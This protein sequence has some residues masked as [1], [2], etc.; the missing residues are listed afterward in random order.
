MLPLLDVEL[1]VN[2]N[3]CEAQI[4][5]SKSLICIYLFFITEPNDPDIPADQIRLLE[6]LKVTHQNA[7]GSSA[8][9]SMRLMRDLR[10]IYQSS[11]YKANDFEVEL[12]DEELYKWNVKV[13]KID[14]DSPLAKDM[15]KLKEKENIDYIQL[16]ILFT[17]NF[18]FDPPFVRVVYPIMMGGFVKTGGAICLDLLTPD[19]W[20][21]AYSIEA[22]ITQVATFLT[23]GNAR[24]N[25]E[26]NRDTYNYRRARATYDHIIRMHKKHGW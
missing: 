2:L 9:A 13:K 25:F 18:P 6:K 26:A 8:N 14:Q 1:D 24:I 12:I 4:V 10:E 19:G 15:L 17:D 3:G 22:V 20:S 21:S 16:S 23:K 5:L 11:S 7:G